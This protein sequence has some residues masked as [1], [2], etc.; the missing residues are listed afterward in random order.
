MEFN[1]F[2]SS[3]PPH[4]IYEIICSLDLPSTKLRLVTSK[5]RKIK[6]LRFHM[7]DNDSA[8]P[9][10]AHDTPHK[11]YSASCQ[12]PPSSLSS[13]TQPVNIR[14]TSRADLTHTDRAVPLCNPKTQLTIPAP[15][16]NSQTNHSTHLIIS[17]P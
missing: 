17:Y 1:L 11:H 9:T 7:H 6:S 8:D 3:E 15:A 13:I 14:S 5:R 10:C 16:K 12:P 2:M 4:R